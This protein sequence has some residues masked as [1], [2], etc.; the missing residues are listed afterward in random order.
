MTKNIL[1]LDF[2]GVICDSAKECLVSACATR[3]AAAGQSFVPRLDSVTPDLS[4]AFFRMRPY[5]RDGADYLYILY[6]AEHGVPIGGQDDFDRHAETC[7][8]A[9]CRTYEVAD[10]AGLERRFQAVREEVRAEDEA[11]WLRLNPLYPG[12]AAGLDACRAAWE[13]VFVVT[14][15]PSGPAGRILEANDIILPAGHIL[16]SDTVAK[17]NGKNAHLAA[18]QR[19]TGAAYERIHFVD[20]QLSHL[21]AARPLGVRCYLASW[22]YNGAEQIAAAEAA[23]IVVH[24]EDGLAAWMDALTAEQGDRAGRA[25]APAAARSSRA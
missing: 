25:A 8:E 1:A 19:T 23:G 4:V 22:G 10:R 7:T 17:A 16:G 9:I 14:A 13:S 18:V 15:K 2:D 11:G 20:D 24:R 6:F 5:I 3:A 12:M 21:A